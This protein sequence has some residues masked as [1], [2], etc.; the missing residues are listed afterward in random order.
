MQLIAVVCVAIGAVC[1]TAAE[2]LVG[3][4]AAAAASSVSEEACCDDKPM[5]VWNVGQFPVFFASFVR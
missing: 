1:A 3:D 5:K 4:T 2:A